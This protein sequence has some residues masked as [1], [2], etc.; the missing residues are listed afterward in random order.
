[1]NKWPVL[2]CTSIFILSVIGCKMIQTTGPSETVVSFEEIET[3]LPSNETKVVATITTHV[4]EKAPAASVEIA[5]QP[6][7]TISIA[8]T[9]T[10]SGLTP[11]GKPSPEPQKLPDQPGIT[12]TPEPLYLPTD[13]PSPPGIA[14][15]LFQA[16]VEASEPGQSI[17]LE[18]ATSNAITVTLWKLAPT[19]QFSRFWNVDSAGTFDYTIDEWERNQTTF[20]LSVADAAGNSKMATVAVELNCMDEWFF[21]NPPDVCPYTTTLDSKAAVQYFERG[22]MIWIEKED[23]IYVLFEDGSSPKWN[24]Y[25]DEWDPGEPDRDPTL[26]APSG[27]FQPVRGFGLIWREESSTGERLGWATGEELAF[28]SAL[29]RTSYPKYNETYIKA[30]N[31]TVWRLL[32]ERSG[33]ELIQG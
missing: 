20:A 24:A 19:G 12:K 2:F 28:S 25:A 9:E 33:W 29:Q 21:A 13:T 7:A 4:S 10:G 14:I 32:A 15:D 1:M 23:R 6:T 16:D 31:G 22:L 27:F 11:A 8:S 3:G 5:V 30:L 17:T 26:T 18:W